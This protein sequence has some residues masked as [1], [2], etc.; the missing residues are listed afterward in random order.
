M[1]ILPGI[2]F[3][4]DCVNF[5]IY[6]D[7]GLIAGMAI[8]EDAEVKKWESKGPQTSGNR[9]TIKLQYDFALFDTGESVEWDASKEL[10]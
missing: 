6:N 3:E 2:A 7:F 10:D 4:G 9:S 5:R 8:H 1:V